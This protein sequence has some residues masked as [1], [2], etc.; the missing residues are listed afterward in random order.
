MKNST[1]FRNYKLLSE[2]GHTDEE[3]IKI[4][5]EKGVD[6][7]KM[8]EDKTLI[9]PSEM[10][11][12]FPTVDVPFVGEM[13]K[14]EWDNR[15]KSVDKL[16]DFLVNIMREVGQGA[17]FNTTDELEAYLRSETGG[18]SFD[19]E[20]KIVQ[21]K[22]KKFRNSPEN[23]S[24]DFD[25]FGMS[26]STGSQ[27]AGGLLIPFA[28]T[29][30]LLTKLPLLAPKA[31]ELI[32]NL[33]KKTI[34]GSLAGAETGY[35]YGVGDS[36]GNI[37]DRMSS[38]KATN[39]AKT[40]SLIGAP[41]GAGGHLLGIG[42]NKISDKLLGKDR[43]AMQ[44]VITAA[45]M[46]RTELKDLDELL[47]EII[48][49][50]DE[51]LAEMMTLADLARK[52]GMLQK[53]AEVTSLASPKV[54]GDAHSTFSNRATKFPEIARDTVKNLLGR[55]V[56]DPDSFVKRI[57][58]FS[59]NIAQP[60]YDL[61]DPVVVDIP[62]VASEINRLMS[63][64]DSVGKMVRR[65]WAKTRVKLPQLIKKKMERGV[66]MKTE[67]FGPWGAEGKLDFARR[68]ATIPK[69]KAGGPVPIMYYDTFKRYLDQEL[70]TMAKNIKGDTLA[71]LDEGEL[72]KLRESL[73]K[74]L[75]ELS[76]D[77]KKATSIWENAHN[78]SKAFKLGIKHHKDTS[79]SS[80]MVRNSVNSFSD[81][82][83]K[84]YRLGY[85]S[86][87][88]S[89]IL[90]KN[91][92]SANE[93]KILRLFSEE[94]PAKLNYLF[95]T[96][97]IALDFVNKIKTIGNMDKLGKQVLKGS[98]TFQRQQIDMLLKGNP[99]AFTKTI[100]A[101]RSLRGLGKAPGDIS[102]ALDDS[103]VRSQMQNVGEL[104]T[105]PGVQN[106]KKII[107]DLM[108]E[109]NR[110]ANQLKGESQ[111]PALLPTLLSP[112]YRDWEKPPKVFDYSKD[113]VQSLLF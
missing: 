55:R 4:F 98:P 79:V 89:K 22:I 49:R 47:D 77:Y 46:D 92:Q 73:N 63:Q 90:N 85:A 28:L 112:M 58:K 11:E 31:G 88:Y 96:P 9:P 93:A 45:K 14:E 102:S 18:G 82:Q 40:G 20:L 50:G 107:K 29:A 61:A 36:Q 65:A 62:K 78:N 75:R 7:Q 84:A 43:K 17:S 1:I 72:L 32:K 41:L 86:G 5:E 56:Y 100:D 113:L 35:L 87:M 54:L 27:V 30:K 10:G 109:E 83:K 68:I 57:F 99:S 13:P 26:P 42:L 16:G 37:F 76:P 70:S 64:D 23:K 15:E 111:S 108:E 25:V 69:E 33:A 103:Q 94:E 8:R 110:W 104:V 24:G 39:Y 52:G 66:D 38:D 101:F 34:G 67:G 106:N 97:E 105:K 48:L 91:L 3:I 59:K 44:S 80:Q 19:E 74:S 51:E 95:T 81:S 60:F 6:L 21:D 2:S 12:F 71:K 53:T